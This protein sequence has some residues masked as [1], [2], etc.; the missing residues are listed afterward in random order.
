MQHTQLDRPFG[1]GFT[2]L[3][4]GAEWSAVAITRALAGAAGLMDENLYPAYFEDAD[5]A[6]RVSLSGFRAARLPDTPLLHGQLDGGTD[7]L[8]G[9]F[10]Q[11]YLHPQVSGAELARRR[12]EQFRGALAGKKYLERKWGVSV[13]RF[14]EDGSYHGPSAA[15]R[16]AAPQLNCK[17]VDSINGDGGCNPTHKTPFGLP[18]AGLDYW[19]MDW[20]A[21]TAVLGG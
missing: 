3:C 4:C 11:L 12:R 8:S 2:S 19:Q 1:I 21:R 9:L 17:S 6:V 13:G 20:V 14:S 10:E 18:G 16:Q 15:E 5:Y 7:Y